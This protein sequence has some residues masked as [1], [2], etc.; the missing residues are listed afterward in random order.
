MRLLLLF[1]QSLCAV[2][3]D[4]HLFHL[5]LHQDVLFSEV[6]RL[7]L[8]PTVEMVI[9]G[10]Q[11]FLESH[12]LLAEKRLLGTG[13]AGCTLVIPD[14]SAFKVQLAFDF[15]DVL[16]ELPICFSKVS[17]LPEQLI[18]ILLEFSPPTVVDVFLKLQ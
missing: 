5:L 11:L 1:V 17:K 2:Q 6:V 16:F 10:V 12:D 18:L 3:P 13:Q 9:E 8:Q 4:S 7:V 15:T 14:D